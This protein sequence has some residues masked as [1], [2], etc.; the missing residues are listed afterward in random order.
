MILRSIILKKIFSLL[1]LIAFLSGCVVNNCSKIEPKITYCP[2][3]RILECLPSPFPP[4]TDE[5]SFTEWGKELYCGRQ[6]AKE[7]DFYRAITCYKR[8]LF[9]APL[10]HKF[11][12]EY[13]LVEAYYLARKYEDAIEVFESSGLGEI[14]MNAPGANELVLMLYDSYKKTGRCLKAEKML[15]LIEMR[16]FD[17]KENLIEFTAIEE[18][19][20]CTLIELETADPG[21]SCFL[22]TYRTL[23]KS[24][25][26]A[27]MLNAILPGAGYAYVGQNKTAA[28]AF[29]VNALFIWAAYEFFHRGYTAAGIITTSFEMGWYFGGIN[30]AGLAAKEL[31]EMTYS[32]IGK[33]YLVQKRGFPLLMF[34]YA[35]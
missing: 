28:T 8:A 32:Q 23:A 25:A 12:I 6:F 7:F 21:L 24:P 19:D 17:L 34:Q 9:F 27:Q 5:E 4:L 20:F 2:S 14:Q 16:N 3:P 30:G 10:E 29:V 18:A 26:K 13:H 31:N 15:H 33:E 22:N 11:V 35:F 1:I